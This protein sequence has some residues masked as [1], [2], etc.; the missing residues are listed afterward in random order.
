MIGDGGGRVK[1]ARNGDCR[2]KTLADDHERD[3][4]NDFRVPRRAHRAAID[5]RRGHDDD[6]GGDNVVSVE[7]SRGQ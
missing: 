1:K 6:G 4:Q 7:S 3:E 2:H 5:H